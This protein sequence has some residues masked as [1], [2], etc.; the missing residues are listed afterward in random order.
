MSVLAFGS[1][2]TLL[3]SLLLGNFV[4]FRDPRSSVNRAFMLLCLSFGYWAFTEFGLRLAGSYFIALFWLRATFLWPVAVALILRFALVFSGR[5]RW[6]GS[7]PFA[8]ALYG[9][10][11]LFSGAALLTDSILGVPVPRPWGWSSAVPEPTALFLLA[12]AWGI[13]VALVALSLCYAHY[14]GAVDPVR[15]GQARSVWIGLGFPVLAGAVTEGLLPMFGLRPPELGTLAGTVGIAFIAY[16]IWR[17]RLFPLTPAVVAEQIVS[18]MTNLLLLLNE[19]GTILLA[20]PAARKL[21]G[22]EEQG[23]V[24]Q[25]IAKIL[26]EQS[27][28]LNALRIDRHR[29]RGAGTYDRHHVEMNLLRSDGTRLPVL[30]SV[31]LFQDEARGHRCFVCVGT[32]LT[33]QKAAEE[34]I[35]RLNLDLEKRVR[36][37]TA[38]LEKAYRDLKHLD[39]SKD[40]FLSSVSHELRTPLTSIRSFSEILLH[41]EDEDPAVRK[42][43]LE[44]IHSESERLTRLINDVLDLSK[45]EAGR[46]VYRDELVSL[47]EIVREVARSQQR[48]LREKSLRLQ[49]SV[50]TE[51][52]PVLL[53]RDRIQQV[54]TNLLGN[55]VKFS[56]RGGEI[57]VVAE[58][59][60]GK[61]SR[62]ASAWV[63]VSVSDDGVGIERKD[64]SR[65]FEK[66]RQAPSDTLEE[67]PRGT[68]L[69]LPICKEIVAHYGGNVWVESEPGEGSTF[70][71]SLPAAPTPA[72]GP[73]PSPLPRPE[74]GGQAR[75]TV[76][77]VDENRNIRRA[78][79][80]QLER[81]G[82]G[83]EE[84]ATGSEALDRLRAVPVDL[85]TLDLIMPLM[86]GHDILQVLRED[87]DMKDIPILIVSTVEG[88]RTDLRMGANGFLSKPFREEALIRQVSNLLGE[89]KRSVLVV[90]DNPGIRETLRTRLAAAGHTVHVAA[91]GEEAVAF[92][93]EQVPGLVIL[94]V[95]MPRMDGYEVLRWIRNQPQTR[96]LPVIIL[97]AYSLSSA[98]ADLLELGIQ[99][100]VS[101]PEGVD[102]LME[103]IDEVL[104]PQAR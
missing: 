10:A 19:E 2:V 74:V 67:K 42:E 64:F 1:L 92:L 84:A 76:L 3:L 37:R 12:H 26:D 53:D 56:H 4:Y 23:L 54:I 28:D 82:Y 75:R 35:L 57:R 65:I 87:P 101:K 90:D 38:D 34:E 45:I 39:T 59:F 29:G 9:P 55:A 86:D 22:Y 41:Y 5:S 103:R 63:K 72:P 89:A 50:P 43:F 100:F 46:M 85:I 18:S 70:H 102:S 40:V 48:I 71:F 91:D 20:N 15:R 62:E 52:P 78:L 58:P 95:V 94:D 8:L 80:Y 88:P 25:P 60:R 81:R 104:A 16:G 13:A 73:A 97:S 17:H 99:A 14:A 21:L 96:D 68:G 51:M 30:L 49:V 66:F 93:R 27:L 69:G 7:R 36:E 44:I 32:D 31:S 79:R 47:E 77:V 83:V 98:T 11:V 24:N 33:R 61:R 6:L